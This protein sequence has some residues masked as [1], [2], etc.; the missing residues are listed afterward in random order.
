MKNLFNKTTFAIA[1]LLCVFILGISPSMIIS[2]FI[3][4]ITDVTFQDCITTAPFVIFSG[5][6]II[7][8]SIYINEEITN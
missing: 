1:I 4:I 2:T 7:I 3:V 8:S 6:G 5:I